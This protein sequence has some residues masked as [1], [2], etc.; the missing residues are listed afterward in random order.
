MTMQKIILQTVLQGEND[1]AEVSKNLDTV[2]TD[3]K[4]MFGPSK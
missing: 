3:L 1:F 2:S 4:I